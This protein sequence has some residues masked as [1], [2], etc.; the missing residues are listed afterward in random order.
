MAVK[1]HA[2]EGGDILEVYA[3]VLRLDSVGR[4]ASDLK[5]PQSHDQGNKG[6]YENE[7]DPPQPSAENLN[8]NRVK[9]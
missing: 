2:S 6:P 5:Q 3:I 7:N 9:T 4:A 1:D 8:R